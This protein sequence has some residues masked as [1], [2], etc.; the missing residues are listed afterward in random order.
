MKR[1]QGVDAMK[2]L[3]DSLLRI[4]VFLGVFALVHSLLAFRQLSYTAPVYA[5][6]ALMS[7]IAVYHLFLIENFAAL[8]AGLT[9]ITFS[10]LVVNMCLPIINSGEGVVLLSIVLASI[11]EMVLL[12]TC[13][14]CTAVYNVVVKIFDILLKE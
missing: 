12:I 13:F 6:L 11:I 4:N 14:V 3:T 7:Y 10:M 5:L 2:K 8:F 9:G 1:L